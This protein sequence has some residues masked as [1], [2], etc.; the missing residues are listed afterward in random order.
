MSTT[1]KK[2]PGQ[3]SNGPLNFKSGDLLSDILI[4]SFE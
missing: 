4:S 3:K 2:G 1:N